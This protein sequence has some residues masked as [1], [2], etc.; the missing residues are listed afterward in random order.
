M[1]SMKRFGHGLVILLAF[2]ATGCGSPGLRGTRGSDWVRTG[3]HDAYPREA[4]LVGLGR[5]RTLQA[6][7]DN[8]RAEVAK[9]FEARVEQVTRERETYVEGESSS[10]ASGWSRALD[11]SQATEV[12]TGK[13]LSG[14]EIVER[15]E[16]PDG[17]AALAVLS[18]ADAS[19][20]LWRRARELVG[21]AEALLK[22]AREAGDPLEAARSYYQAARLLGLV[23]RLNTDIAVLAV[24]PPVKGPMSPGEA[25]EEFRAVVREH[26]PVAVRVSGD[27]AERIRAAVEAALTERGVPVAGPGTQER[28]QVRGHSAMRFSD[29]PPREYRFVRYEVTLEA[30]DTRTGTVWASVGPVSDDASGRTADQAVER[31]VFLVRKRHLPQF[32]ADLF[33]RL[34][35]AGVEKEL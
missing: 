6:A 16:G 33:E 7:E 25:F 28:L 13:V 9:V 17:F 10:G 22:K 14:V 1:W 32:M 15:H 34:F 23:E 31:A 21:R 12:E 30:V 5:G 11:I 26:V 3:Q 35:G 27:E 29:R 19:E 8:A 18:R 4:Y 20:R 24:R 2:S